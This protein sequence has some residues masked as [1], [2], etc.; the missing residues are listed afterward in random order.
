MPSS[1][2]RN[3]EAAGQGTEKVCLYAQSFLE[4][5]DYKVVLDGASTQEIEKATAKYNLDV[6][7]PDESMGEFALGEV[8][9]RYSESCTRIG[10]SE[11]LNEEE[12]EFVD[13]LVDN[14]SEYSEADEVFDCL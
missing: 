6:W 13:D 7:R 1:N 8:E 4:S 14:F 2:P 11:T 5:C 12:R 10:I 3:Y 9:V